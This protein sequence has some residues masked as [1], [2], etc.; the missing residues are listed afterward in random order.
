[1]SHRALRTSVVASGLLVLFACS[2]PAAAC[3]VEEAVQT[4]PTPMNATETRFF[5]KASATNDTVW[6]HLKAI[7]RIAGAAGNNVANITPSQQ[8]AINKHLNAIYDA[9]DTW[10]GFSDYTQRQK[11]VENTWFKLVNTYKD[12][13]NALADVLWK[14]T[15]EHKALLK[16]YLDRASQLDKKYRKQARAFVRSTVSTQ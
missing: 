12:A 4:G 6:K 7:T 1:M 14:P 9:C 11:K 13:T 3:A 8:K 10:D 5:K 15:G 16:K 2:R